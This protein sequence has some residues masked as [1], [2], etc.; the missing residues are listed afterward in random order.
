MANRGRLKALGPGLLM[1][2]AAIGVSHLVQSTRAGAIYGFGL[3]GLVILA[4]VAKYPAFRFGPAYATA[5]GTSLLEGYRRQGKWA[6][7]LYFVVTL[8][9]MFTVQAAVAVVCAGLL[10]V[11][12]GLE[13]SAPTLAVGL[14]ALC[15]GILAVGR[16]KWLDGIN[17]VIIVILTLATLI[18]TALT[19]PGID[20]GAM[21]W[22]PESTSTADIFFFAAL[23]GWMPSAIDIS[24]WNSLWTLARRQETGHTPSRDEAMFDFHLG[25]WGT[26][27]LAVCFLVLGAGVMYGRGVDFAAG[28]GGFAN[29]II[30]LYTAS[31]GEWSRPLIGGCAFLVMFSTTLAVVD[32]FPRALAVLGLRARRIEVPW[33]AED[34]PRTDADGVGGFRIAYWSSLIILAVGAAV[35]LFTLMTSLKAMVDLATTLSF[36]TAPLLA[37]LN[38]RAMFDESVPADHRPTPLLR[39]AS[40]A[41]ITFLGLFAAY[42][43]WLRFLGQTP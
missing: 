13:A 6:L 5:T 18:A 12:L 19:L 9:T 24:V 2:G 39:L 16:F 10:K 23:V 35:V 7:A 17:K 14:I 11:L 33:S 40:L 21:P 36:L 34:K 15:A 37:A 30:D 1:A 32:G 8:G 4:N 41:G 43:V 38:H 29:Q 3:I 31:L 28:A 22:W 27:L 42:Y 26:A 25:Y 20:F